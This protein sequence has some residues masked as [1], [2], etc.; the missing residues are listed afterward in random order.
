MPL[1]NSQYGEL[2]REYNARQLRNQ[3]ITELRAKEAY[4]KIPRLKE[5]DDAIAS[6]S[7][8]QAACLKQ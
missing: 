4:R 7:V 3:R 1:N 8:A 6:C 5:I 2:I